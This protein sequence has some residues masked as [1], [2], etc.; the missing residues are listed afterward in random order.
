MS[1]S[2]KCIDL[3]AGC[4]GLSTGLHLAGWHG[5][6]AVERNLSAFSTLKA[7]LIEKRKHFDWPSWLRVSNWDIKKLLTQKHRDLAKLCGTVDLVTGGPPCAG[8]S[9]AGRPRE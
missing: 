3:D 4:G 6:F 9:M 5:L 8:F 1:S 7:N 2:L